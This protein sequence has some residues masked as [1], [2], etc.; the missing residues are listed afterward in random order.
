MGTKGIEILGINAEELIAK[1]NRA[2]ADEWFAY[3]QYWVGA[4]VI[5]GP[6][7]EV[8]AAE[9]IEH[10]ADELRH[11][12]MLSSRIV[13]LGGTPI[14]SPAEWEKLS[15]CSYEA[16]ADPFVKKILE[17]NIKGEQCAIQVYNDILQMVK[18]K[19]PVT[20]SIVLQILTD[21][22]EHEDD[23]QAVMEDFEL[24]QRKD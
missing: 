13:Q 19:D 8:A 15:H 1:L 23:L 9:L 10:A 24:L 4:K 5:K 2:L 12:D 22:I 3:Y 11:A 14:L 17:Q 18:D 6:M 7:R 21:E 20:Y 16:P